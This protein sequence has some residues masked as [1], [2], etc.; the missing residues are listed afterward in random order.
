LSN[1]KLSNYQVHYTRLF[2]N[3]TTSLIIQIP[4]FKDWMKTSK[5]SVT[6]SDG[7]VQNMKYTSNLLRY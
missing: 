6:Q 4:L 7:S 5:P 1:K 3:L 2:P